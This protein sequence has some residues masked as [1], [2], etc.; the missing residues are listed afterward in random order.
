MALLV[1]QCPHC[2][3]PRSPMASVAFIEQP[4]SKKK[5]GFFV[6]QICSKPI[7]VWLKK[8]ATVQG[9]S[10]VHELHKWQQTIEDGGWSVTDFWPELQETRA[11]DDV[12]E[13][14]ANNFIQAEEAAARG[15]REAAGMAYR[16]S[17]ELALKDVAPELGGMLKTR[18]D[19]LSKDGRLTPDLKDWA[20][21]VRDLGN[22]AAHEE[23]Q[24]TGV[25]IQDLA[26]FT[27]VVLEYLYTMPA[28][29]T[30]RAGGAEVEEEPE[31]DS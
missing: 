15:H 4:G 23:S 14:V 10:A 18:I 13:R 19:K 16:R 26:A 29:V 8:E 24:P 20:H 9:A 12:P 3:T 30:R 28:K 2:K 6:C 5:V 22:E 1:R 31:N 7:G 25:D 11:P 17:L 27:R 21:S